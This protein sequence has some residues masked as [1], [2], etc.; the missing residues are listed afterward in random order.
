MNHDHSNGSGMKHLLLMAACCLIPIVGIIAV[1][2]F[3]VSLG[4]LRGVLPFAMAL[5]CPLI[6][7][8]MMRGMMQGQGQHEHHSEPMQKLAPVLGAKAATEPAR[9]EQMTGPHCGHVQSS[10]QHDSTALAK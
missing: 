1:G 5:M 2:V 6:M 10:G 9:D 4:P 7:I 8:L 3:G